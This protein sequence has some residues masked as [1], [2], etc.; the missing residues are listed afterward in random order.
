MADLPLSEKA[1]NT[2]YIPTGYEHVQSSIASKRKIAEALLASRMPDNARSWTQVLGNLAEAW[3]GRNLQKDAD[4]EQAG[5]EEAIKAEA[6]KANAAFDADVA[7]GLP[8]DTMIQKHGGNRWLEP[9]M[10]PFLDAQAAGLKNKQ[11]VGDPKE[12]LGPDGKPITVQFDKAGG[13]R[14]VAG[15]LQLPPV[16]TDVNGVATALQ[17]Q[18]P[19]TVLPQNQGNL[20]ILGPDGKPQVNAPLLG[21]KTQIAQAGNP[22][23]T[24]IEVNTAKA[25]G[26]GAEQ[27]LSESQA[28]ATGALESLN[29]VK[30][31][32]ATLSSG[33]LITGPGTSW[34]MA[35]RRLFGGDD[36]KLAE[37]RAGIQGLATLVLNQRGKLKGQGSVSDNE[38]KLLER[39]TTDQIDSMS[40]AE[41]AE[42]VRITKRTNLW[43]L[44]H[45]NELYQRATKIPGAGPALELY[46]VDIP[47]EY[48]PKPP[49]AAPRAN[50]K[51]SMAPPKSP[52]QG[53]TPQQAAMVKEAFRRNR[54]Q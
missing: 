12:M 20:V 8:I 37:T 9:R 27:I 44:K 6:A 22:G 28:A 5:V 31:L 32:E 1:S 21:A 42:V 30:A 40:P 35:A 4:K 19:G 11:E 29:T 14:P 45:H 43:Q 25:F 34:S 24:K 10:K 15:G 7:A 36:K 26:D 47:P 16:I 46:R 13:Q 33:K 2:P 51:G 38:G 48:L 41:I 3:A 39:A 49:A 18:A 52:T 17:H 23:P 54:G 53:L 50:P